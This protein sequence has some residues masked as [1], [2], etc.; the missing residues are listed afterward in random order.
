MADRVLQVRF[1][2]N[3]SDLAGNIDGVSGKFG[4]LAKGV[5]AA[6]A[7]VGAGLLAAGKGLL[8]IGATFDDV[9][10]T[11]RT[12]TGATGEKLDGLVQT[13]KNVGT[14]VPS[15]FADVGTAVAGLNQRLGVTGP[16]LEGLAMQVLDLS[17]LTGTDLQQNIEGVTRVFG[18]WGIATADQSNAMDKMFTAS[19]VTGVSITTLQENLVKFG[20]PLRQLGFSFEQS[21]AML[22]KF[23]KEGVNTELVMGSMRIALGKMA[24]QGKEPIAAFREM[25]EKIKSAGDAGTANKLALELFG[26][27]AGPDMA[28]AIREGRFAIDDLVKTISDG[29]GSIQSAAEDTADFAEQWQILK[30]QVFVALEPVAARVFGMINDKMDQLSEWFR[31]NRSSVEGFVSVLGTGFGIIVSAIGTLVGSLVSLGLSIASVVSWIRDHWVVAMMIALPLLLL[32]GPHFIALGIAATVNMAKVAIAW[33]TSAA[34][35]TTSAAAHSL[36]LLSQIPHW[37]RVGLYATINA[38]YV[39][40]A[41][42][43]SAVS[44]VAGAAAQAGALIATAARWVWA[45]AV[46]TAQAIRMA[47]AWFI[48]MGPIGWVIA[49]VIGL[50]ALIIANWDTVKRWTQ[51]AWDFVSRKVSEAWEWIKRIVGD[52]IAWVVRKFWEW[53]DEAKRFPDRIRDAVGNLG[54]VLW[55]AGV[56]LIS[57]FWEG[58]RSRWN[59]LVSWFRDAMNGLR[60]MFPFS[61]AK[62][63]PFSGRGYV[64]HSGK[65]LTA[66]FAASIRAGMPQVAAA[67]RSIL[68][69]AQGGFSASITPLVAAA[70]SGGATPAAAARDVALRVVGSADQ[71]VATLIMQLIREGKI[72]LG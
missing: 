17:R 1:V 4:V 57:G 37:I 54:N 60:R 10:D 14:A 71:A 34:T 53:V 44:A 27:K 15:S 5:A 21:A 19:Q 43:T 7:A 67:V 35:A 63:G 38:A 31:V 6:G 72:Q 30:N 40:A 56:S 12:Q 48:A 29:E 59:Q 52:A 62:E 24:K 28:A 46:A 33:A 69:A 2:G 32:F 26:A 65:A 22:G 20:A 49:A 13:A 41:W 16:H 55:N 39:V 45:G 23:E 61:P 36:A 11:I 9:S 25:T 3:T 8:D 50:V 64:T 68:G 51:Q 47:A 66:D 18:D 58:I 70:P 42:V